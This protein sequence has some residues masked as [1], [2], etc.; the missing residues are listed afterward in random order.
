VRAT[1]PRAQVLPITARTIG[2]VL[3]YALGFFAALPLALIRFGMSAD[4]ALGLPPI[5]SAIAKALAVLLAALGAHVLLGS[6]WQLW[7]RGRGLPISHLP[8]AR[9][10]RSGYFERVRHPIY[11]GYSLLFVGVGCALRSVG[12]A[13]LAATVLVLAWCSYA[14][15]I[16]EP[17][18]IAR[19]G[20]AYEARLVKTQRVP[21]PRLFDERVLKRAWLWLRPLAERIANR[22]VWFASGDALWVGYGG[23]L[24][25]G[26]AA[27]ASIAALLFARSLPPRAIYEYEL[28][29]VL[30]MLAGGRLAWL[31]Y[32]YRSLLAQPLNTFRRVGFVS[33]GAYLSM[34]AFV[35]LWPRFC[36]PELGSLW[37]LD[38]TML[39]CL[40]CSGFGRV[41]C[42]SYGCCYGKPCCE[43]I[44]YWHPQSKVLRERSADGS[45][46]RAPTQLLSSLLAFGAAALLALLLGGGAPPGFAS[47]YSAL[48]YGLV[49]FNIEGLREE[50]RFFANRLTRGQF[51]SAAIALLALLTIPCLPLA[52]SAQ[53]AALVDWRLDTLLEFWPLPLLAALPVFLVC[54]YH[55][56]HVGSW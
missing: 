1:E 55:R 24:A 56:R 47:L 9:L 44:R 5:P 43:G 39:A 23:L 31:G 15:F 16:E 25:L 54:G 8:P 26:A 38:R 29:L 46:A 20:A 32:E 2:I 10:V 13:M 45:V 19:F 41:G 48:A 21:L 33:F 18:H 52:R 12:V 27:A 49:R 14:A 42:L 53:P 17:M 37:F 50:Q 36:A 22:P 28:G 11:V 6:M 30:C 51:A 35:A 3:A 40:V 7:Q 4:L 34:F